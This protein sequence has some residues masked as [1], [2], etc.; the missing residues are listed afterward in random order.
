MTSTATSE[1]GE[2]GQVSNNLMR[3]SIS[4]FHIVFMVTAAAAPLVVVSLYI[5]ISL[6]AGAGMATALTYATTTVILLIF[7]IG[8]AQMAKRITSAGA[9]IPSPQQG[10]GALSGLAW[11]SQFWRATA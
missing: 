4:F 1:A 6:A 11:A 7:S 3:S 8:F 2:Q 5:P 10:S 9:S